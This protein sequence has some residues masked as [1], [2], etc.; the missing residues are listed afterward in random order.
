MSLDRDQARVLPCRRKTA[1]LY[2]VVATLEV[3]EGRSWA[4]NGMRLGYNLVTVYS[5]DRMPASIIMIGLKI[6]LFFL[7]HD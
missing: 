6:P 2:I 7:A 1:R 5:E 3:G 4:V